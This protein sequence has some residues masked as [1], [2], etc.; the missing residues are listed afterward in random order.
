MIEKQ[1]K[2]QNKMTTIEDWN[3]LMDEMMEYYQHPSEA[4]VDAMFTTFMD[5]VSYDGDKSYELIYQVFTDQYQD[6]LNVNNF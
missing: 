3:D 4:S 1:Q 5:N 2:P 6:W